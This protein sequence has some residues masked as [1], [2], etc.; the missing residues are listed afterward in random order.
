M[1]SLRHRIYPVG[2]ITEGQG[3]VLEKSDGTR[4]DITFQGYEHLAAGNK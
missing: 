2:M 1:N 3:V 4:S